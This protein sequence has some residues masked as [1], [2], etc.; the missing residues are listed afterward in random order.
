MVIQKHAHIL[1]YQNV[2]ELNLNWIYSVSYQQT[3]RNNQE[4][5][6]KPEHKEY[7]VSIIWINAVSGY[8]FNKDIYP[9]MP[10][11]YVY[12]YYSWVTVTVQVLSINFYIFAVSINYL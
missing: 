2:E 12:V 1:Q 10:S 5:H 9:S 3:V 7:S 11:I 4:S 6:L 8:P